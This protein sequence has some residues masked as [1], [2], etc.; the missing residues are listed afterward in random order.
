MHGGER[1]DITDLQN[2][3]LFAMGIAKSV[4]TRYSFI[5]EVSAAEG[6]IV[7]RVEAIHGKTIGSENNSDGYGKQAEQ[8][9]V[10]GAAAD[11]KRQG[12]GVCRLRSVPRWLHYR[13]HG[14]HW[15]CNCIL[16]SDAFS[17]FTD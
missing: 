3:A 1:I 8:Q 10:D 4:L 12:F 11:H 5:R 15:R 17:P 6:V 2:V 9:W 14:A 16:S 7:R 13:Y